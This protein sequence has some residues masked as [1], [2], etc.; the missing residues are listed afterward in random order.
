MTRRVATLCHNIWFTGSLPT[1]QLS[2]SQHE[3]ELATFAIL[4]K[5]YR[6]RIYLPTYTRQTPRNVLQQRKKHDPKRTRT[7]NLLV[8]FDTRVTRG[9]VVERWPHFGDA[10]R[11]FVEHDVTVVF[12]KLE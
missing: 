4:S 6:P 7:K 3:N 5:L 11:V 9:C 12:N 10:M 8:Y 2:S 1:A